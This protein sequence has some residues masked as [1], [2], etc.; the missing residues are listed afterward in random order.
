MTWMEGPQILQSLSGS[1]ML[2]VTDA[3][4]T[5]GANYLSM[6]CAP[7]AQHS[8]VRMNKGLT[9]GS[10]IMDFL[11]IGTRLLQEP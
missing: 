2:G 7:E 1:Y 9:F 11:I 3:S 6:Y 4:A 5:S 8:I 10:S